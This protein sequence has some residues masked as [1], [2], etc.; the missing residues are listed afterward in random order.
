MIE[1]IVNM[2]LIGLGIYVA[3]VGLYF[4]AYIGL[5]IIGGV[6]YVFTKR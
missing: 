2:G 3:I 5:Q 4:L 6:L 1:F